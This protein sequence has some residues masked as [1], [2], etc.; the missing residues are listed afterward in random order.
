M[1]PPHHILRTGCVCVSFFVSLPRR[2]RTLASFSVQQQKSQSP[3]YTFFCDGG[4]R[5][6]WFAFEDVK[7]VLKGRLLL[8]VLAAA[9]LVG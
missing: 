2:V 9:R 3:S 5:G 1:T 7:R 8:A 4:R 6:T